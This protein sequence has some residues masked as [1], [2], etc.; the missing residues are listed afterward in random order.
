MVNALI[1]ANR[2]KAL[3]SFKRNEVIEQLMQSSTPRK[4][5]MEIVE[6]A[7]TPSGMTDTYVES[8]FNQIHRVF[9]GDLQ[10]NKP[11]LTGNEEKDM[12]LFSRYLETLFWRKMVS[13]DG[14]YGK[15]EYTVMK[16]EVVNN[17]Q[18]PALFANAVACI[19]IV[20]VHKLAIQ[21]KPV[22][23]DDYNWQERILNQKQWV[24]VTSWIEQLVEWGFQAYEGFNAQREGVLDFMLM[25]VAEEDAMDV[26]SEVEEVEEATEAAKG[27]GRTCRFVIKSQQA[28]SNI[29]ALYRYFFHNEKVKFLTDERRVYS[30]SSYEATEEVVDYIVR[31]MIYDNN[32]PHFLDNGQSG[33]GN[34]HS[35]DIIDKSVDN[36]I[37]E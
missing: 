11:I 14:K 13:V 5:K 34:T 35:V 21:L 23:A 12:D 24:Q 9:R 8:W 18:A 15:G 33:A 26:V 16:H 30:Y 6:V 36:D 29:V 19:G 37:T 22:F 17:V 10:I 3:G 20:T 7:F 32:V 4:E 25:S 28:S 31:S 1:E 2:K 27:R